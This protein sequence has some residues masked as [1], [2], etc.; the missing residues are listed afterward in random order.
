MSDH[1]TDSAGT[2]DRRTLLRAG[3]WAAPV[4]VIAATAP[5]AAAS[6]ATASGELT[7]TNLSYYWSYG[8][9]GLITGLTANT[10]V[11]FAPGGSGTIDSITLVIS[12]EN[13]D[14]Q[15]LVGGVPVLRQ[16]GPRWNAAGGGVTVDVGGVAWIRYTF[17][18]T[19]P[20]TPGT[21]TPL[22]EATVPLTVG[23]P[24]APPVSPWTAIASAPGGS[25]QPAT[26]QGT[27]AEFLDL[28]PTP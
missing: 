17:L 27:G 26:G 6:N 22:L 12:I 23:H 4:I 25:V 13:A 10:T 7:F 19:G 18:C 8:D 3:A 9:G 1:T 20:V 5:A 14:D 16:G 15:Y 28:G 21:F 11:G 24:S 2:I